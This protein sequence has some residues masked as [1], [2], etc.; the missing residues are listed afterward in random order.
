MWLEGLWRLTMRVASKL[1]GQPERVLE[2]SGS[3]Q[4]LLITAQP[5]LLHPRRCVSI[6]HSWNY[7]EQI[8]LNVPLS[9]SDCSALELFA[10]GY[11]MLKSHWELSPK[12]SVRGFAKN[13]QLGTQSFV[14]HE[15]LLILKICWYLNHPFKRLYIPVLSSWE[16]RAPQR[17]CSV[18]F[19]VR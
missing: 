1:S 19:V 8:W 7:S 4:A 18:T 3:V 15:E 13:K 9:F 17:C 10:Q 11:V 12:V 6:A 2:G 5:H 16:F 14:P